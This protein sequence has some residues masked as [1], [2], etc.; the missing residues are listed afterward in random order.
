VA[1][2]LKPVA[3]AT[4]AA[5]LGHAALADDSS[6]RHRWLFEIDAGYVSADSP[7]GAWTEGG[8]GKLRYA[9]SNDGLNSARLFAE[10]RGR[11]SD[12]WSATVVADYVDD[13]SAGVDVAEAFVDW[14]PVPTSGNQQ[15]IRIGAFYPP[16][17]L[18]NTDAGW[19]SPFT[20]SYSAINTWLGEEIRPIGAEW[21]LHRRLGY[22]G[23]PHQ[24]R[25]FASAFYGNDPAGTLLFWRGWSLHDRQTRLND[26]LPM[27]PK[28]IF[29][30]TGAVVGHTEQSVEPFEEIDHE[31]GYYAGVEWTYRQ[32]VRVEL[33]RY[34]N[35][36]DPYAF[37]GGQWSW[38]TAFTHVG[39]QAS[40][41]WQ[42]GVVG[43]WLDGSTRWVQ[44][45]PSNG[46]LTPFSMLVEDEIGSKFLML[47]RVIHGSHRVSLRYDTFD[48]YRENMT[49]EFYSDEG[50]AWTL[51]YRYEHSARLGGGLELLRIE[52]SRDVWEDFYFVP[53]HAVE[54]QARLQ[55]TYRVGTAAR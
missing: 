36:A 29:D 40:L 51:G 43:Q 28:P 50:K 48:V 23:S 53:E 2:L 41:P 1:T 13:A 17:S 21:S 39:F 33:A 26:R 10:Y 46:V 11:I 47:T 3:V 9:E 19:H 4:L 24:L 54:R 6:D 8:L 31:P 14:R 42:L 20:Y 27:P 37:S 34:D 49:P 32:R 35:R 15:Q 5:S 16:F 7:L 12:A 22:A 45:A 30:L 18:E 55:V 25:A 38:D 44:G 52:S